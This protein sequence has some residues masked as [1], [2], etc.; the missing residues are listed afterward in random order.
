MRGIIRSLLQYFDPAA[1][2]Y[3][4]MGPDLERSQDSEEDCEHSESNS[5]LSYSTADDSETESYCTASESDADD[6][7]SEESEIQ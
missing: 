3:R 6:E 2:K 5:E 1:N 7:W 4:G